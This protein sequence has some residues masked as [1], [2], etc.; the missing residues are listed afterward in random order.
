MEEAMDLIIG[1]GG[2]GGYRFGQVVNIKI[3]INDADI[4]FG[5]SQRSGDQGGYRSGDV[6]G[7]KGEREV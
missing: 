3:M 2:T 7:L 1:G 6:S 4:M 5:D